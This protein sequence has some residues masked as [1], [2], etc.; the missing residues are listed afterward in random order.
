MTEQLAAAFRART[1]PKAEWTHHAHLRVGLWYLLRFPPG[2]ALNLL[3]DGIRAF[4]GA[5]GGV[6]SDSEGYHESITRFYV[7]QIARFLDGVDHSRPLDAL[8]DELIGRYGDR[9]LPLRY[10]S[11][12]CL[13]SAEARLQWVEPDLAKLE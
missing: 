13:M 10:W 12:S 7:W 9:G 3:R 4:N 11:R 8:A 5:A 2:E 6:N 1:L